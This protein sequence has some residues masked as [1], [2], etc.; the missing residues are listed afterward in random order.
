MRRFLLPTAALLLTLV[1]PAGADPSAAP[2]AEAPAGL[3][4]LSPVIERFD[5]TAIRLVFRK[6]GEEQ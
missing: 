2:T 6:R 1:L 3:S 5:G 4:F